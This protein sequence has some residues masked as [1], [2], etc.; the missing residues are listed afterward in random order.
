MVAGIVGAGLGAVIWSSPIRNP[1]QTAV[2]FGLA[3]VSVG[4]AFLIGDRQRDR[5][6]REQEQ[7]ASRAERE[8]LL[9][10]ERDQ[11]SEMTAATER[12]RIARELHDIVA[13]SLSVIVVQADGGL[14]AS[15]TKPEVAPQV[16]ATIAETSRDALAEMRRMVAVLRA[17]GPPESDHPDYAPAPSAA[18][19]PELVDQVRRAGLPVDLVVAGAQRPVG[20]A[21]GLT[22]YRVVQE[23][24]TNVL[25]HGGPQAHAEVS[26]FYGPSDVTVTVLDDGR[27]AAATAPL[28]GTGNGLLGMRERVELLGG[29]AGRSSAPRWGLPGLRLR[30]GRPAGIRD[31]TGRTEI[32]M[33]DRIG[34]FLVDD[35]MLVRTGFGMLI[36]AQDDLTVVGEAGDGAAA[37]AALAPGRPAREAADVVLMD[38]RM[39]VMD[40]VEAT[41]RITAEPD[42]PRVLV[43]TTFDLDEYVF[44]ALRAGASGFLLKDARPDDLLGAIR[45][46]AAGDAV[47]APSATRRLLAHVTHALPAHRRARPAAGHADRPGAGGA[48]A[49][50]RRRQQRRDRGVVV[51]GRGHGQDTRRASAGQARVPGP[52]RPRRPGLRVRSGPGGGV[53]HRTGAPTGQCCRWQLDEAENDDVGAFDEFRSTVARVRPRS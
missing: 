50:G 14:A 21:V 47:V 30:S 37:V 3:A 28:D 25:K 52:G 41:R 38:V 8:R 19:L 24:L 6:D 46:V 27:G 15:R 7:T 42:G 16:L 23:S 17:G 34:V 53:D 31:G 22:M 5:V 4:I 18:D 36:N 11:R 9:T 45:A 32:G 49:G 43:L 48:A 1:Q 26:V 51:H 33:T 12:A 35:Q 2:A 20:P 10:I 29:S 44:A 40:G 39:P 13:H